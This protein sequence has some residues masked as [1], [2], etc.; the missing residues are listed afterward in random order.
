[1]AVDAKF[2]NCSVQKED[3]NWNGSTDENADENADENSD[4][5][6]D[7]NLTIANVLEI[8]IKDNKKHREKAIKFIL[9]NF[10]YLAHEEKWQKFIQNNVEVF[11]EVF[12]E[13]VK[14]HSKEISLRAQDML[15]KPNG[16][17]L[18]KRN[19]R[20]MFDDDIMKDVI[21]YTGDGKFLTAHSYPLMAVSEY[22]K[23]IFQSIPKEERFKVK[24]FRVHQSLDTM[25]EMLN[26]IYKGEIDVTT[27]NVL[28]ILEA[29]DF[30]SFFV[31]EFSK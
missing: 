26:Y 9:E 30:V 25:M 13:S 11:C 19:D 18:T 12:D 7:E 6:A 29:A 22:F 16:A 4:E 21:F 5:N 2:K 15:F 24:E 27:E 23:N 28:D 10:I 14:L 3:E 8:A 31:F 17:L 20:Q 1:M